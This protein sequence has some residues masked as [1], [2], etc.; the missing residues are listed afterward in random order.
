MVGTSTSAGHVSL[1]SSA[2]RR[3][4]SDLV[5]LA[6]HVESTKLERDPEPW[7]R[8][9]AGTG[10]IGPLEGHRPKSD[11]GPAGSSCTKSSLRPGTPFGAR[12]ARDQRVGGP[13]FGARH[14]RRGGAVGPHRLGGVKERTGA[15]GRR[16]AV[17]PRIELRAR[18]RLLVSHPAHTS[19]RTGLAVPQGARRGRDRGRRRAG[20]SA[21]PAPGGRSGRCRE[22]RAGCSTEAS[23]QAAGP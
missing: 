15:G 16:I 14:R 10:G 18:T 12:P 17:E 9:R 5:A 4:R 20:R 7:S 13:R 8:S 3:R 1:A 23:S 11:A 19:T 6:A 21:R 22:T 2:Y